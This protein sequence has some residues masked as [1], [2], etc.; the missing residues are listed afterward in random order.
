MSLESG[1][2]KRCGRWCALAA[3]LAVSVPSW[4][5]ASISFSEAHTPSAPA[6]DTSSIKPVIPT[7][8]RYQAGKVFLEHADVWSYTEQPD[9]PPQEQ[10][11]V[12]TGNVAFRKSDM[13]M[14]CDSAH[15]Y[16]QSSNFDA[17]GNVRMEQGD[18][19]FVYG[20]VL[21]YD[22]STSIATLYGEGGRQV[23]LINR[24]VTLTTDVFYYDIAEN[25]G[26][27]DAYGVLSDSKNRL[28]SVQGEY[29]PDTKYAYFSRAVKLTSPNN[30]D[31]LQLTT[32]SLVYNTATHIAELVAPTLITSAD[33]DIH[34]SSGVYNTETGLADLYK[35]STVVTR[36]GNTLTGD[37][38]FY[39]RDRGVGKAFGNM[40][41][42]DSARQSS[43]SGDYGFYNDNADSAFVTGHALVKEYSRPDT[44]YM[45]GDT[46]Y[47]YMEPDST[48]ITNI[49]HRVRFYRRDVQG[50]CDS[51]SASD[52]DSLLKMFRHPVVW[53][54][55]RQVFGNLI[56]VH[57]NDS[58]VDWARL[59][60][61]GFMAEHIDEDCY[62]QMSGKDMTVWFNDSTVRRLYVEGNVQ[63]IMFPMESDSTYNKYSYVE[64]SEMDA[65]FADNDVESVHFRP[66]TTAKVVPLYLAKKNSY[67]LPKFSWYDPI[68]PRSPEDVF[69]IPL[70]ME[71]LMRSAPPAPEMEEKKTVKR[72][73][74]APKPEEEGSG[75]NQ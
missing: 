43:I 51:L 20:D 9:L 4:M 55:N 11:Q 47:A 33:G 13:Y 2:G 45:H 48:R 3:A 6:R 37:T 34:S 15:F 57:L 75:S 1:H 64:S 12:L 60:N 36:R 32:D 73:L 23:K 62:Q 52:R 29:Y 69:L 44:L 26:Y 22:D 17:Y 71:E 31:T 61:F 41:L 65:Y 53:S 63:L 25:V 56:H 68:R 40:L 18:T 10:Y 14:Y 58:T 5:A 7:A 59:P 8:D 21:E 35:R 24:D 66:A 39:D 70:E 74:L 30:N 50:I 72:K 19:L 54:D 38:L 46:V 67:F 28:S 49:Y 27:Y 42:T 16:E